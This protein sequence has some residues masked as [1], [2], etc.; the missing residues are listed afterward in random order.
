MTTI[1]RQILFLIKKDNLLF[2]KDDKY[3]SLYFS[4]LFF[5]ITQHCSFAD[6]ISFIIQNVHVNLK[7]NKFM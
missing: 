4:N 5:Y 7:E 6:I 2:L 3:Q 1:K